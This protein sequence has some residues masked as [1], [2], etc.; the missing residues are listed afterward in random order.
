MDICVENIR[1][2]E[3]VQTLIDLNGFNSHSPRLI[4][5]NP[6]E[7]LPPPIYTGQKVTVGTHMFEYDP[8]TGGKR[9]QVAGIIIFDTTVRM[10]FAEMKGEEARKTDIQTDAYAR[11]FTINAIYFRLQNMALLDPTGSGIEDLR[12]KVFRTPKRP[13]STFL[14]DPIRVIR[15]LRFASRLHNDGFTISKET[16]QTS[17]DP[18]IRVLS[19]YPL[20]LTV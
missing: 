14:D 4:P 2:A 13:K 20:M 10:E 6:G 8:G 16:F 19:E 17:I 9:L 3:F 15:L 12:R 7:T 1:P 11:E 5:L 18:D